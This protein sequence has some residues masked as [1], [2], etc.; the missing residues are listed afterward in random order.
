[1]LS[2]LRAALED[3]LLLQSAKSQFAAAAA[4]AA[5]P[6]PLGQTD[7]QLGGDETTQR[8]TPYVKSL[9]YRNLA[10]LYVD[11]EMRVCLRRTRT[12]P[13][14]A[15]VEWDVWVE[16]PEGGLAVKGSAV[17]TGVAKDP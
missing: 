1:M 17:T 8:T 9:S 15:E 16:G 14:G 12:R 2:A 10:P 6:L 3:K 11:E 5:A 13:A 7:R 4:A